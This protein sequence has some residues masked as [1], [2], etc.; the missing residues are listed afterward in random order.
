MIRQFFSINTI[1]I[2][3]IAE[4]QEPGDV[5]VP[6][7]KISDLIFVPDNTDIQISVCPYTSVTY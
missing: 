5:Y 1:N 6:F 2:I 7:L 3:K 4:M